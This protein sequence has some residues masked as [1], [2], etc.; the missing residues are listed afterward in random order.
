M[1]CSYLFTGD[2]SVASRRWNDVSFRQRVLL[3]RQ[4]LRPPPLPS[5]SQFPR[6]VIATAANGSFTNQSPGTRSCFSSLF[7]GDIGNNDNGNG[8]SGGG[9]GGWWFNG[10]DNSSDDDSS[11]SHPFR[12]LCLLLFLVLSCFF[13]LR[14]SA[15]FAIARAPEETEDTVWE[16]R[17]SKRKRLVPDY[18]EDEFVVSKEPALDLSSSLTP[19]NLLAQCRNLLIQFLLPEGYPNSVT[20]DYLDYSLWRGVQ[21]IASQI[22]GV[23]ATQSLLYAVGL[24]KGAI[25][26]AAAIN[27]VLKDGIGYLS[28]IMLSKYGRHFDVHPKGWRL[29]ADLLENAAFGME[30]LTPL[31]PHFFV[32]IGAAAGAGRSAAALIQAATKSCFN[33][34]F[35]SQRNFAEVIAKGEAQ[36]MVSKSMGILLGIVIANSIGTSTSLALAAFGVVTSIHMYTNFKSYQCIQLRTLNPY[37]ASLVFSEYLISGQAPL[38]KEVNDEEPVFPAVRF[39][40]IKSPKKLQEFVLSSEAKAAAADIEERLQ[41]GSK[42]SEVIHNKEEAIALFD[43]YRDEGYILTEHKGRF[44][45][46]LKESSSPQDMLR[47][48]FQVNYL[49]WLEKNAGIEATNTYSDCKPGGRLHISLDYVR[50]E[51]ELAKED[52]ET[53]GWVTEGLIA[54]PLPTR[55]RLGYDSEPSSSSPSSS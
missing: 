41:L 23:L 24:G 54:R 37:R 50:R 20:S 45:V 25:P 11:S 52:S 7:A 47:S 21:G 38:V 13:Q 32:M 15:A 31:F 36:G 14:L 42:L 27:W 18:V 4:S 40:N 16:V 9:D 33:A 43:L 39:L 48:L 28:K 10:G 55:I 49:Y 44:C 35:A 22:S 51:F 34:G 30:M 53:V 26:T 8:S 17:G 3:P 5:L 29:F 46:T 2:A 6:L 1:S 19:E 12:F